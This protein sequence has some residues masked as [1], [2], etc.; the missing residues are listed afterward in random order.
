M[1]IERANKNHLPEILFGTRRGVNKEAN[2]PKGLGVGRAISERGRRVSLSERCGSVFAVAA[3]VCRALLK[4]YNL[5][6][7]RVHSGR[8]GGEA[9]FSSRAPTLWMKTPSSENIRKN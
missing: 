2:V 5:P 6:I 9:L 4:I 8:V 7:N 1:T 3:A